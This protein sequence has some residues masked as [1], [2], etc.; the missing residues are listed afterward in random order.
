MA[1]ARGRGH[2]RVSSKSSFV[3][4]CVVGLVVFFLMFFRS[5]R[6]EDFSVSKAINAPVREEVFGGLR[7][8]KKKTVAWATTVTGDGEFLVDAA[9]VLVES[10]RR[11][12]S[13]SRYDVKFVALVSPK[14]SNGT[15]QLLK[16]V[17]FDEVLEKELPIEPSLIK[18]K[19]LREKW[20]KDPTK[21][22]C[23]GAWELLKLYAWT[24]TQ[25]HRV[26]H[27]DVDTMSLQAIDELLDLNY[28]LIYTADYNMMS[29]AQRHKNI[30]PAVQG[31][32][33]VIKPDLQVFEALKKVAQDGKWG[34]DYGSGWEKSNI[35]YWW[36]G[37]T[38]QGLLPFFFAVKD[39]TNALEVDRC[40]Y[41]NMVDRPVQSPPPRVG[42]IACR[43]APIENIKFVHFTVCQKPWSCRP[44]KDPDDTRQLCLKL[45]SLWFEI[46]S[47]VE[48]R[49]R[50][51]TIKVPCSKQQ[52]E[53]SRSRGK[54]LQYLPMAFPP[55]PIDS[56]S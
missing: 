14:V 6:Q 17:G 25:Y 22:G 1:V 7:F 27:V 32:F 12:S 49:F 51:K 5:G 33:L 2:Q 44:S 16:F 23:C 28:S 45:H 54:R 31:G 15:R 29:E 41:D 43:H 8:R 38:I 37:N 19:V 20:T 13:F 55:P 35:G 36:G 39:P 11:S 3:F 18:G 34:G 4:G 40:I 48:T 21:G 10:A 9:A 52:G 26:I 30:A 53:G 24:L 42:Q 56:Y 46:R 50:L 47:H